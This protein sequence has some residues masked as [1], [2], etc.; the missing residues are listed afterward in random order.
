MKR[1]K[2]GK[3]FREVDRLCRCASAFGNM[4]QLTI[5]LVYHGVCGGEVGRGVGGQTPGVDPISEDVLHCVNALTPTPS[6]T[7][8]KMQRHV[9]YW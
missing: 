9:Q 8:A 2:D 1:E 6:I 4:D 7:L 5:V 3:R